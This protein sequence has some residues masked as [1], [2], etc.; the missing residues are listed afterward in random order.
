VRQL[1]LNQLNIWLL[2]VVVAV[3][4]ATQALPMAVVVVVQVDHST[5]HSQ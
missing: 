5:H 1:Y 2:L 4:Q 3:Q